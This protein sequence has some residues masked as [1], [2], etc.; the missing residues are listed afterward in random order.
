[1]AFFKKKFE[2]H[3]IESSLKTFV[4]SYIFKNVHSLKFI[5]SRLFIINTFRYNSV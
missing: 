4:S 2:L 1:M 3:N 5:C